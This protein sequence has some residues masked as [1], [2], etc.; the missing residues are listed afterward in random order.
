MT[1]RL[2]A[3]L[4]GYR[5][6]TLTAVV[7]GLV[8]G[9]AAM[10]L[11]APAGA[12]AHVPT[13]TGIGRFTGQYVWENTATQHELARGID[14]LICSAADGATIDLKSWFLV[15][16][17]PLVHGMVSRLRL[18]Q[19]YH[20]VHVN[21][22]VGYSPRHPYSSVKKTFYFAH[23]AICR[24]A[25]LNPRSP[26]VSHSKWITVSRLRS[27]GATAL[28]ST[29]TNWSHGQFTLSE[30]GLLVVG[31]RS[32]YN[33]FVTRWNSSSRCASVRCTTP[34]SASWLG[35]GAV[36]VMFFPVGTGDAIAGELSRA[37]CRSGGSLRLSSL[38][39]S[40]PAVVVQLE[41]ARAR[42]CVVRVVLGV[43]PTAA[44][45]RALTP[46]VGHIHDKMLLITTPHVNEVISG[47]ANFTGSGL[48][49]NDEQLTRSSG[50]QVRNKYRSFFDYVWSHTPVGHST[51][52]AAV[53]H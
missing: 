18:M 44:T 29:S 14:S 35:S 19:H 27:T 52:A 8:A 37:A 26:A 50:S 12:T 47:S 21:V 22:L 46:H 41:Q 40:R 31:D 28:L 16:D 5:R 3:R 39:L 32:L 1:T 51:A 13:C 49:T 43:E 15:D 10:S 17:D 38:F 53:E 25:C 30:S 34:Q 42:G 36:R 6:R 9:A 23:V 48:R 45:S 7:A 2:R 20:H 33:A 11:A 4:R 24:Y